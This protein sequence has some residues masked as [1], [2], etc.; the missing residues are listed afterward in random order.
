VFPDA[1]WFP[2]HLYPEIFDVNS[3]GERTAKD[4]SWMTSDMIGG[5]E[6]EKKVRS[7]TDVDD[8][9]SDGP[10]TVHKMSDGLAEGIGQ[11]ISWAEWMCLERMSDQERM[12]EEVCVYSLVCDMDFFVFVESI[13]SCANA[14]A[15]RVPK[16]SIS[17]HLPLSSA[18]PLIRS[19]ARH[20]GSLVRHHT[21]SGAG[22]A[23]TASSHT[24]G[25]QVQS[26]AP[27][28]HN[29]KMT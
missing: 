19:L 2:N 12:S 8:F 14:A 1:I 3:D 15:R 5:W 29:T 28:H 6:L 10:H 11:V 7:R 17:E 18:W 27:E 22:T 25:P 4:Y 20:Y 16:V 24:G 23:A 13:T 9:R 21:S 26:H